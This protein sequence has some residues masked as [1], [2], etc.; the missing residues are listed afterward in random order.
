[1]DIPLGIFWHPLFIVMAGDRPTGI[2]RRLT[3]SQIF[4][5]LHIKCT[6]KVQKSWTILMPLAICVPL[7]KHNLNLKATSIPL[8]AVNETVLIHLLGQNKKL[9]I[10]IRNQN[11]LK[12]PQIQLQVICY[13]TQF[14]LSIMHASYFLFA[15]PWHKPTYVDLSLC[16]LLYD[17][18]L[19]WSKIRIIFGIYHAHSLVFVNNKGD[20]KQHVTKF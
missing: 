16:T 10:K 3:F 5:Y 1:M 13:Y 20:T 19:I 15:S 18:S 11:E 14:T 12:A 8:H 7:T 4:Y 6:T 9:I 17:W 2:I